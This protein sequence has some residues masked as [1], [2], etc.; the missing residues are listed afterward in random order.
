MISA[1]DL[2]D[3]ADE[4]DEAEAEASVAWG[5]VSRCEEALRIAQSEADLRRY[6]AEEARRVYKELTEQVRKEADVP[7]SA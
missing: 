6:R 5:N 2:I 3:A 7:G 1:K 4:A